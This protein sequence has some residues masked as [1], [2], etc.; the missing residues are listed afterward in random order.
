MFLEHLNRLHQKVVKIQGV[1]GFEQFLIFEVKRVRRVIG[2]NFV[3]SRR[4]HVL[5]SSQ[6]IFRV[7]NGCCGIR[8]RRKIEVVPIFQCF[9]CFLDEFVLIAG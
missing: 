3:A 1:V 6:P 8:G 2:Y 4:V 9:E 5:A 7:A